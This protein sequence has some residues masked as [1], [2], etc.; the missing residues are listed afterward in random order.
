MAQPT[1]YTGSPAKRRTR[2]LSTCLGQRRR[3]SSP[4]LNGLLEPKNPLHFLPYEEQ[5]EAFP[6]KPKTSQQNLSKRLGARYFKK[7]FSKT[8]SNV[9]KQKRIAYAQAHQY[10]T[11]KAFWGWI[12]FTD[13]AHFNSRELYDKQEYELHIPDSQSRLKN[14]Q[15]V[16]GSQLNVTVH[17]AAGISYHGNGIFEFY[18]DQA[19]PTLI[20]SISLAVHACQVLELKRN[21]WLLY[22]T[23]KHQ[24]QWR[25][26]SN[27]KAIQ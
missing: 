14:L 1:R 9:N 22:R 27:L 13:E 19:E 5:A 23:R 4:D 24:I 3:I 17:V 25:S 15:E 11:V 12:Y 16:G 26:K 2:K 8:I 18:N 10:K 21:I 7:P 20:G 6:V